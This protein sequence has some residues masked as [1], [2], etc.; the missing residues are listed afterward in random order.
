ML[1]M[2]LSV[3]AVLIPAS[4]ASAT[5]CYIEDPVVDQVYCALYGTPKPYEV[6][7]K[8]PIC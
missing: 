6:C 7:V 5:T 3:L 1:L 8:L 4:P 2:S